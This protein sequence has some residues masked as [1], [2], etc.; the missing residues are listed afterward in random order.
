MKTF[1]ELHTELSGSDIQ[2]SLK[3]LRKKAAETGFSYGILKKVYDR[4]MA[5]WKGGHRPGATP[6]QWALARVNS[7]VTGGKTRHTADADLWK[8]TGKG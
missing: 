1:K 6:H 8:Q 7:F 5:A 3:A 2:E 4:G